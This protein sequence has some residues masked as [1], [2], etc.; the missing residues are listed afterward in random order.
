MTTQLKNVTASGGYS[1]RL[2]I[3]EDVSKTSSGNS[4]QKFLVRLYGGKLIEKNDV[5]KAGK[6]ET[7]EGIVF[8]ANGVH[9]LGPKLLGVFDGG[10]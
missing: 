9:G 4:T 5:I 8:F 2:Y 1:G 7:S 6:C 10:R 3:V